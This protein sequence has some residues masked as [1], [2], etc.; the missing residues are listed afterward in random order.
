MIYLCGLLLKGIFK[1]LFL[2]KKEMLKKE[3]NKG[4]IC[5]RFNLR[6]FRGLSVNISYLFFDLF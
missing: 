4:N 6:F 5:F 2:K 3:W 1:L